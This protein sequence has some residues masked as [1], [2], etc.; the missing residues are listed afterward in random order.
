VSRT[1]ALA[2]WCASIAIGCHETSTES[3]ELPDRADYGTHVQ[4]VVELSCA[5]LDCHG[6]DGRPLRLYSE[7]GLRSRDD[8]RGLPITP[9]ELERNVRAF[10]GVGVGDGDVGEHLALLKPL[11]QSA[12]GL[13]HEGRDLW[14]SERHAGYRCL[15]AWLSGEGELADACAEELTRLEE[16]GFTA[17]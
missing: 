5:T 13:H 12:G 11:S 16:R 4:G 10:A 14:P 3:I 6:D 9:E 15:R 17:P 2:V 7:R 8:L 1:F